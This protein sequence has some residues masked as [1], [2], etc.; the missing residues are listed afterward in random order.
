MHTAT[1]A[2]GY[3]FAGLHAYKHVHIISAHESPLLPCMARHN[4][5]QQTPPQHFMRRLMKQIVL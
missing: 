1:L 5:T 3:S 2:T 4:S